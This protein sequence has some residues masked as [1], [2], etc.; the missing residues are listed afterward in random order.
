MDIPK[1]LDGLMEASMPYWRARW[2]AGPRPE[3]TAR[4]LDSRVPGLIWTLLPLADRW[5]ARPLDEFLGCFTPEWHHRVAPVLIEH[6]DMPLEQIE[7]WARGPFR[8]DVH[9]LVG[10]TMMHLWR[11][12]FRDGSA[13]ARAAAALGVTQGRHHLSYDPRSTPPE[14]P[15]PSEARRAAQDDFGLDP[16]DVN[17]LDPMQSLPAPVFAALS[18][19]RMA[20]WPSDE[21]VLTALPESPGV[22]LTVALPAFSR[23]AALT[24]EEIDGW[25]TM[26]AAAGPGALPLAEIRRLC[27]PALAWRLTGVPAAVAPWCAAAKLP[28]DEALAMHRAGTLDPA[29]LRALALLTR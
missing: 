29:G 26:L 22:P 6:A 16:G 27:A 28:P 15:F 5:G 8:G 9:Q 17:L 20:G 23:V 21:A 4:R 10:C 14:L 12:V 13:A 19:F 25:Q 18:R 3:S 24:R 1:Y 2:D 7:E 11:D